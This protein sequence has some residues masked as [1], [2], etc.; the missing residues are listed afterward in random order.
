[1]VAWKEACVMAFLD[2]NERHWRL[3]IRFLAHLDQLMTK[4][5]SCTIGYRS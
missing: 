4:A 2:D 3:I 5:L 1:M